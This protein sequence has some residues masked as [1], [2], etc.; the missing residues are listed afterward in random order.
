[1]QVVMDT[2]VVD[3][4]LGKGLVRITVNEG[5]QYKIGD[6]EVN[7][8]KVFS[9]DDI[10]RMYPFTQ[11]KTKGMTETV[12]GLIGRGQKEENDI[13]NASAW[14]DATNK[15]Q[16]AYG[17]QGY[18]YASIH[19]VVERRRVG[20]DSVPTVDLRW[21]IDERTPAIINRVDFLGNDVT[22]ETCIRDQ[23]NVYPGD[24]FNKERFI[25]SYRNIANL[26]F[27]EQDMPTPENLAGERERRHRSLLPT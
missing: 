16:D 18:I 6:F 27:F 1:M 20:K 5:P 3:K 4:D 8:A 22:V 24:V 14:D 12:K 7:G 19:P 11:S 26:G 13:F 23:L 10:S 15:V 25:Q 9:N 21:D 17:N 2:L